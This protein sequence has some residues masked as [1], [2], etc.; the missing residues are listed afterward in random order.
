MIQQ[1]NNNHNNNNKAGKQNKAL[2]QKVVH[3]PIHERYK[4]HQPTELEKVDKMSLR[5]LGL[6]SKM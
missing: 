1:H 6:Y 3:K 4:R 2:V 5:S